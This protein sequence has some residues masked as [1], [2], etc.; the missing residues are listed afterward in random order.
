M[1]QMTWQHVSSRKDCP[2]SSAGSS[3]LKTLVAPVATSGRGK[4]R[5]LRRTATRSSWPRRATP[6]ILPCSKPYRM[7]FRGASMRSRSRLLRRPCSLCTRRF[8]P[9]QSRSLSA[10]SRAAPA[11]S[12]MLLRVP[13]RRR[14]FSESC[15]AY[16][17]SSTLCTFR[18]T[19]AAQR[20]D[21][22][23]PAIRLFRSELFR[24]PCSTSRKTNCGR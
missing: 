22:P 24:P 21:Q 11:S 2:I 9:K 13:A 4:R 23:S 20:S 16:R 12:A 6:S 1:I 8:K 17:F 5:K 7:I 19:V 10:S 14:T 3:T 18:S 15:F